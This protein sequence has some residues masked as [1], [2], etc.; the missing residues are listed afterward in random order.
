MRIVGYSWPPNSLS[1]LI[2]SN[3]IFCCPEKLKPLGDL[4]ICV[5]FL[6]S[7]HDSTAHNN[8][9]QFSPQTDFSSQLSVVVEIVASVSTFQKPWVSRRVC[10]SYFTPPLKDVHCQN[11]LCTYWSDREI[12]SIHCKWKYAFSLFFLLRYYYQSPLKI[13][14][15]CSPT[16]FHIPYNKTCFTF[17]YSLNKYPLSYPVCQTLF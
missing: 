14:L 1:T 4:Y 10:L 5:Q 3:D 2:T 12:V 11:N 7:F 9:L 17:I 13:S 15:P 16:H 6:R 8:F